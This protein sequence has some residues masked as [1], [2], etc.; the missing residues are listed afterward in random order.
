MNLAGAFPRVQPLARPT[1]SERV[2]RE[3]ATMISS[4]GIQPGQKLAPEPE[5][6]RALGVGRS[7]L[8]EAVA[9]LIFIGMLK[10]R[11]GEGTFVMEGPTRMFDQIVGHGIFS[12]EK[13]ISDLVH[14]RLVLESE[15]ATL[16]AKFATAKDLRLLE[17]LLERMGEALKSG[18]DDFLN[19]DVDFHMAIAAGS[20]NQIL[21]KL[22][23]T[24]R[25]LLGQYI[26]QSLQ[27]PN[28]AQVAYEQHAAILASL[29]KRNP[30]KA[31]LEM[32][33]HLG[34]YQRGF[35]LIKAAEQDAAAPT[36]SDSRQSG[37]RPYP[38]P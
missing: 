24:I 12:T 33:K 9:C 1:L 30:T 2:A 18:S 32:Q 20:G 28:A 11:A 3:I 10:V 19:L 21:A 37:R 4:G 27:M 38:V 16:C 5:L 17:D 29:R 8:R 25:G 23:S 14:T 26:S 6:C 15:T 22:L 31:R 13:D 7:T 34:T 35:K 36:A